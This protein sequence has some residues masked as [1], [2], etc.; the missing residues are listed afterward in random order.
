M[1]T[2]GLEGSSPLADFTTDVPDLVEALL[3]NGSNWAET[4]PARADIIF[5]NDADNNYGDFHIHCTF[6]RTESSPDILGSKSYS[7][8]DQVAIH[9]SVRVPTA[10]TKPAQLGK[11]KRQ[12]DKIIA[13][14]CTALGQ[15]IRYISIPQ[16]GNPEQ[17]RSEQTK[18]VVVG[19]CDIVYRKVNTA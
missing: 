18:W 1:S 7:Y 9:V 15:Q 16:W 8:N 6:G 14:N 11:M 3:N 4:D 12:I 2:W 19:I 5:G 13:Q 10:N 17:L